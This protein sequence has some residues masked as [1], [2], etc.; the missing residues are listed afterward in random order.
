MTFQTILDMVVENVGVSLEWVIILIFCLGTI[1]FAAKDFKLFIIVLFTMTAGLFIWF[2]EVGL[3]YTL[4][5]S[6]FFISLV[7]LVLSLFS[8]DKSSTTG[9]FI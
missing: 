7:V 9:G 1:I 5:L 8:V 4:P 2:Y 6:I 3:D